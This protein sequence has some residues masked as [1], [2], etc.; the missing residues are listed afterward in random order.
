MTAMTM[1]STLTTSP[2]SLLNDGDD[3]EPMEVD[4]WPQDTSFDVSSNWAFGMFFFFSFDIY[5]LLTTLLGSTS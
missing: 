5:M 2:L 4:Q 1:N 3:I